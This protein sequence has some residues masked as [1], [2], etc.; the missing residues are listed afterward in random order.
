MV[1]EK[2]I[3]KIDLQYRAEKTD[4]EKKEIK[5]Y[6][7]VFNTPE[8]YGYTDDI[9]EHALDDADMSDVVL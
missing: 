6:A 7:V 1:K 8:T 4:E 5:G 3:R 9:D 2:E